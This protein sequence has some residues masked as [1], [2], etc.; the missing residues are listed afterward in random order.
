LFEAMHEAGQKTPLD[1]VKRIIVV[2]VNSLSVPTTTWAKAEDAPGTVPVLI[3]ATGVPIDRYSG[4]QID[5]LK[6]IEARWKILRQLRDSGA[7]TNDINPATAIVRN[8]P[9][10]QL[11]AIDVSFAQL[12][13]RAEQAYLN[14]LPTC[15]DGRGSR[16]AA[17]RRRQ[18]H[19]RFA[20]FPAAA[21]GC[22]RED[23]RPARRQAEGL[24]VSCDAPLRG[25]DR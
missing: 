14:Q 2:I 23:R 19:P 7:L 6:D 16:P 13:D 5:Q 3:K 12:K 11:Y 4:E 8:A 9:N 25:P 22:W 21:E 20:R 15:L 17:C 10:A 24:T 18:D 1:H